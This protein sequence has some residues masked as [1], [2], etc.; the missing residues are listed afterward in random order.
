MQYPWFENADEIPFKQPT[1]A[2][3]KGSCQIFLAEL[4]R[5]PNCLTFRLVYLKNAKNRLSTKDAG[6][7]R[8][9]KTLEESK[10]RQSFFLIFA[11]SGWM[12]VRPG[13]QRPHILNWRLLWERQPSRLAKACL[14]NS[15]AVKQSSSRCF[16]IPSFYLM[17]FKSRLHHFSTLRDE[18]PCESKS[19]SNTRIDGLGH[20]FSR[21]S[22][23]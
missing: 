8:K 22:V 20:H 18:P 23:V 10:K 15:N 4:V 12:K 11:F 16:F 13:H 17:H 14:P 7:N 6:Q 21:I 2:E 3:L 19:H 5:L 1:N 9:N